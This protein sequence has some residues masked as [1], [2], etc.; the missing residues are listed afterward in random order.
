MVRGSACCLN[1]YYYYYHSSLNHHKDQFGISSSLSFWAVSSSFSECDSSS[2]DGIP[3]V[4][5]DEETVICISSLTVARLGMES[6]CEPSFCE[7]FCAEP[8]LFSVDDKVR[9]DRVLPCG[10]SSKH[11]ALLYKQVDP[12]SSTPVR[13]QSWEQVTMRMVLEPL[14]LLTSFAY[15]FRFYL[16][17]PEAWWLHDLVDAPRP[18]EESGKRQIQSPRGL[19]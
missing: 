15:L 12:K 3:M 2:T 19:Y 7:V 16:N 17:S 10:C 13:P 1:D 18:A 14:S 11:G 4:G 9:G 5:Y 8:L 6:G